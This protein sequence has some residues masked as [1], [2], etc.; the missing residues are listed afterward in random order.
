MSETIVYDKQFSHDVQFL[1]E[2]S[3]DPLMDITTLTNV[4]VKRKWFGN[5][6]NWTDM[7]IKWGMDTFHVDYRRFKASLNRLV[8]Y[9]V[10]TPMS[11]TSRVHI[12]MKYRYLRRDPRYIQSPV[13]KWSDG[14][15]D[16]EESGEESKVE[17]DKPIEVTTPKKVVV[18]EKE[19]ERVAKP[20]VYDK[21]LETLV[22]KWDGET[23]VGV[24]TPI[25]LANS[26]RTCYS[27]SMRMHPTEGIYIENSKCFIC[28]LSSHHLRNPADHLPVNG[29]MMTKDE[30]A[31]V[32]KIAK[33]KCEYYKDKEK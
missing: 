28:G 8:E 32:I 29:K 27:C 22:Y 2:V 19:Q 15:F 18:P 13:A 20:V 5:M 33:L 16:G 25:A 3:P 4:M 6:R 24:P 9:G 7:P 12:V 10:L 1:T 30:V 31:K 26:Y 14:R 23:M 21:N 17:I 11:E